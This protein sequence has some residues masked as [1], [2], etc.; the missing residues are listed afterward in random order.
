[1]NPI[2]KHP[3]I[4]G[5]PTF[6][7]T[8]DQPTRTKESTLKKNP[9]LHRMRPTKGSSK[10][11]FFFKKG[12]G[13]FTKYF[14]IRRPSTINENRAAF[15]RP[16]ESDTSLTVGNLWHHYKRFI[17][18]DQ[19]CPHGVKAC[20]QKM[21]KDE[22]EI[23]KL[24]RLDKSKIDQKKK[25]FIDKKVG[26]IQTMPVYET[27]LLLLSRSESLDQTLSG[28]QF[29]TITRTQKGFTLHFLGAGE[30]TI[31]LAGKEKV[32]R[33]LV[34]K[35]IPSDLF[36]NDPF[37][38]KLITDWVEPEGLEFSR[39]L[40]QNFEMYEKKDLNLDDYTTKS[41]RADKLFWNVLLSIP[42]DKNTETTR[43][44]IRGV[45]LRAEILTLFETFENARHDL[46]PNTKEFKDLQKLHREVSAKVLLHYRKGY[47]SKEDF[48]DLKRKFVRI[49][50]AL[51]E[52]KQPSPKTLPSK[53]SL[54]NHVIE[55]VSL[56]NIPIQKPQEATE[57]QELSGEV[58]PIV[59]DEVVL[60]IDKPIALERY[61]GID[62][63]EA[64]M[65]NLTA[66]HEMKNKEEILRFFH[67]V[68]F[69]DLVVDGKQSPDSFWWQ[70]DKQDARKA[71]EMVL[72]LT[73]EVTHK[74]SVKNI[75]QYDFESL[76][77][78]KQIMKVLNGHTSGIGFF[79]T[80]LLLYNMR[81]HRSLIRSDHLQIK[82]DWRSLFDEYYT[83]G[84]HLGYSTFK[85]TGGNEPNVRLPL[86]SYDLVFR[87]QQAFN[88]LFPIVGMSYF[89]EKKASSDQWIRPIENPYLMAIYL[90]GV[91]RIYYEGDKN[92]SPEAFFDNP[93][94][95]FQYYLEEW[96][97]KPQTH[98][99]LEF[100]PLELKALSRLMRNETPHT[101][102]LAFMKEKPYLL[103]NRDVRN[104]F[105]ALF[106]GKALKDSFKS[107]GFISDDVLI[108]STPLQI[109]EEIQRL[110]DQIQEQKK[111]KIE[112]PTLLKERFELL[113]YYNELLIRLKAHYVLNEFPT[114]NFPDLEQRLQILCE[115]ARAVPALA[116]S[117][118][119]AAR[120]Q[121][122]EQL[123]NKPL[124]PEALSTLLNTYA[125]VYGSYIDPLNV[126]PA[127]EQEMGRHWEMIVEKFSDED[128]SSLLNRF[129][130][131]Q[132]I[133]LD[134]SPWVND[135]EFVFKNAQVS[136]DLKTWKISL[137]NSASVIGFLPTR[138]A[139]DP[140][141]AEED[142]ASK[143]VLIEK[144]EDSTIY[145]FTD[146]K[147]LPTR[148]EESG[149][150][151]RFYK[152]VSIQG[153]DVWLQSLD[154]T[155]NVP[156]AAK[157]GL[158]ASIKEFK[159]AL[160]K[161]NSID[162][163]SRGLYIDPEKKNK[164]YVVNEKGTVDFEV[165]MKP[166]KEGLV[167]QQ[168]FDLR[169]ANRTGPW[170]VNSA[171][172]IKNKSIDLLSSFENK[173][174]ILL[175]SRKG[176]LKKVEMP[177][178]GLSF[179]VANG[180]LTCLTS[181]YVGYLVKLDALTNE[182]KGI[183]QSL[184]LE[185]PDDKR[186]K[187]LLV[188]DPAAL[189][190]ESKLL[191]PK[192]RGFAKIALLY[193]FIRHI[194]EQTL[195]GVVK[196]SI[197]TFDSTKATISHTAFDL[198]PFTGQI[199]NA[200]PNE[201]FKLVQHANLSGQPLL[202]Y[203]YLKQIPLKKVLSDQKLLQEMIRYLESDATEMGGESALKLRLASKL[204]LLLEENNK[205]K[206]PVQE[207]LER[208]IVKN[209]KQLLEEGR[210]IPSQ[211]QLTRKERAHL[212]AIAK[213]KDSDFYQNHITPH[214]VNKGLIPVPQDSSV[215]DKKI[216]KNLPEPIAIEE[217]IQTLEAAINPSI[218]LTDDQLKVNMQLSKVKESILFT[219]NQVK[220]IFNQKKNAL[221]ELKLERKENELPFETLA[222]DEFQ[223]DLDAYKSSEE[224]QDHFTLKTRKSVVNRFV[225][226]KLLPEQ[227]K[228]EA[229][230]ANYKLE[231]EKTL[232]KENKAES[233]MA[234]L[235][236]E[237]SPLNF[238][239]LTLS[240][241]QGTL[242]NEVIKDQLTRY[243]DAL[244][245]LNGADI[246][247]SLINKMQK[248]KV[249]HGKDWELT[250]DELH[251]FL[252]LERRYDPK[253]DPR[254]L[255]FEAL[256]FKNF[257]D[258]PGGLNQLE[259]LESL[260]ND[261]SNLIQAPTGAGK[262]SVLSVLESLLKAN[263]DKLVI[264]KVLPPL[265]NQTEIQAK[266]VLGEL[267]G[268]L[269]MPLR[270][271]MKMPLTKNEIYYEGEE[272]KTKKISIFKGLYEEM[273]EVTQN[274]GL[275]LTDYTSLPI[276][277]AK[278]FKLGGE[279][280]ECAAKGV[281]PTELQ[282]EHFTYL[283]KILILLENKAL[284]SMDEFDQPNRPIQ[285]I[286]LDLGIGSKAI[287]EFM[288]TTTLEIYDL[289]LED[290]EL[291]LAKNIQGDL[292]QNT[293]LEAVRRA[294][295]EM[296]KRLG[297]PDLASYF[298]GESEDILQEVKKMPSELKDKIA[299]CKDQFSIYLP[300]TLNANEGSRYARSNDGSKTVPCQMGEKHDAKFG[301]ILEQINYTIQD[302]VQ[303]G[304]SS[305]DI[306]LWFKEFK[307]EWDNA[308]DPSNLELEFKA[309][310]PEHKVVDLEAL[311][312]KDP[313]SIVKEVNEDPKKVRTFLILRLQAL[314]T[315]G[316]VI[317]LDPV[318]AVDIS[319]AVSGI[320]ATMGA[321]DSLHSQFKVDR[322][323]VGQIKA[324]MAYRIQGRAANKNVLPYDPEKPEEIL[325]DLSKPVQAIIDGA[326]AFRH[327][328]QE[329]A[330]ALLHSNDQLKQ[331]G[332]HNEVDTIVF[333]GVATG[334]LSE[335]GF[336]FPQSKT[337][338][339][340]IALQSTAHA[341]LTISEKDGMRDFSQKEGRLRKEGQTF[342]LAMPKDQAVPTVLSAMSQATC[343]DA[344]IDSKDIYR[345]YRQVFPAVVRKAMKDEL[346]KCEEIEDF[347]TLF[348]NDAVRDLFITRPENSYLEAGSYYKAR[349][350]IQQ[351]DTDP[352]V[353]LEELLEKNKD[354]AKL[355]KLNTTLDTFTFP[356]GV[357]EK[358]P[359]KVG[360][361][362]AE[363]ENELQVEQE[364]EVEAEL[365]EQLEV[366][367]SVEVEEL[368][369][370]GK[371]DLFY[372][373][374]IQSTE[375]TSADQ[376]HPAYDAKLFVSEAFLPFERNKT[377]SP[378]K[379]TAFEP[380]M[381]T[382]GELL[383]STNNNQIENVVLED[384]L[385][386][387]EMLKETSFVYDVRTGKVQGYNLTK[388]WGLRIKK[389]L[390]SPEFNR[391]VAQ[392]K[393]LD[394][395][396]TGYS[397]RE[398]IELEKWLTESDPIEMKRHFK[399]DILRFRYKDKNRFEKAQSQLGD[400]FKELIPG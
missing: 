37:L 9:L 329:A 29:C 196:R 211:L 394:G 343:V 142:F 267:F 248:E 385:R 179:S 137:L 203:S 369:S 166:S 96:D 252:T 235:S 265:F 52:A 42:Q 367:Q 11:A 361:T 74:S 152:K 272:E 338:G 305:Y 224:A 380:S 22:K 158:F 396:T 7:N 326:G 106:F 38:K 266:A 344:L 250:S 244:A 395:R 350:H 63:P 15:I 247:L 228:Q 95:A 55:N 389:I 114:D 171:A 223:N 210:R 70:L 136:I 149:E 391:L 107:H 212:A 78:M 163:F 333:E 319:R 213:N 144:G 197:P 18:Q 315:S 161:E 368:S 236:G 123:K 354:K 313:D 71:M 283:R 77:K 320:S 306:H 187:K 172:S 376:I 35:D 44:S 245:K 175:W 112:D 335:S 93:E 110:S 262:T 131:N 124:P 170:Q 372:P 51:Q 292:S 129:A 285:K 53:V 387:Y 269:V 233:Q 87:Q 276:L 290:P 79:D 284:E 21:E 146:K 205:L 328:N 13:N 393:F 219:P 23:F 88:I 148:I 388:S 118:G 159:K 126:E 201:L 32:Q 279:T 40:I 195:P 141:L 109:E 155:P 133:P 216:Q 331:V 381:Y 128:F 105:D 57:Q 190:V 322:K 82:D 61:S 45:R 181:P 202:A 153:K 113:I 139:N 289:L 49:D 263:G 397:D 28:D 200:S 304:V 99:S 89:V 207:A 309:L 271:N 184:L 302:Y 103:Q 50:D 101:E 392:S 36:K 162:L 73:E 222:L 251:R 318:N 81:L 291:G 4:E 214:F 164:A 165:R 31:D 363:L 351:E 383:I 317:S 111:G 92:L 154:L 150:V 273:L 384:P 227:R 231:I 83:T 325:N 76:M 185:H 198:R 178:Y 316:A 33:N 10:V 5:R 127:F 268:T 229:L 39:D 160:A 226:N 339:T 255:V 241:I 85:K 239:E 102:F 324:G 303:A 54:E 192:A 120:V 147:G 12:W 314:K 359:L 308:A 69:S 256:T 300:L 34:F 334:D 84:F 295:N 157:K 355:L 366:Q 86:E 108:G 340:D 59:K 188:P 206:K 230:M 310:F 261:A 221:P 296:A 125:D 234:I 321:P 68:P 275:I 156:K 373:P 132:K 281:E 116:S 191:P 138:I 307:Q 346:L 270:I 62:S 3:S 390:K 176:Q 249:K 48:R 19:E 30:E 341:L 182:K 151:L 2:Y 356:E 352:K 246:A 360:A 330:R 294:A 237:N 349:K 1:M 377:K 374:R 204:L 60:N 264:Q 260:L 254:L 301:T 238:D 130:T 259:L 173:E 26:E 58:L 364:A 353:A 186:P 332:Y 278:F 75:T 24:S 8:S 98:F 378:F 357:F 297:N 177:R 167:I 43:E 382:V 140:R 362:Q 169:G 16:L 336:Y 20:F 293:R 65:K 121:L 209:G 232:R 6:S 398:L 208:V 189:S 27:K 375:K 299:Y 365:E 386:D 134:D 312:K 135:G 56:S 97:K 47:L 348:Q 115:E 258:L 80:D 104:F 25:A 199:C 220:G 277:E 243:Y 370:K 358:M 64:F 323:A 183:P 180:Q 218:P 193:E 342:Q 168:L 41:S 274:K 240:L 287:P 327:S 242:K 122:R 379:R 117:L 66:V 100:T 17:T 119:F 145:S 337:R 174:E 282:K 399:D 400:L 94:G 298:L 67:E 280:V 217:R 143:Q 286:Q 225:E 253:L 91:T 371:S 14:Q 90:E 347:V 215:V 46:N 72:D 345:H 194:K 257:K 311:F 288:F